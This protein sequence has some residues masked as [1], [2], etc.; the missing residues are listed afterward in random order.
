MDALFIKWAGPDTGWAT[1]WWACMSTDSYPITVDGVTPYK[2][3][4]SWYS[5][6]NNGTYYPRVDIH[7]TGH[8]LGLPDYYDYDAGTGPKGGVGGWDMMDA[9]WGDHNAFSKY[10]LGWIDPIVISSG[11]REINL[12]P[13]STTST[14]NAVLIMPRAAPDSFG[15][16]FLV[17]YREPGS[18]NDPLKAGLGKAVWI[19]HVDSTLS[20]SGW[21]YLYDNS[22]TTHKLL[23]LM[24]AD[25]LEEIESGTGNWDGDDFYRSRSGTGTSD[26]AEYQYVYRCENECCH[27][28]PGDKATLPCM[29]ISEYS[30]MARLQI[31]SQ[32]LLQVPHRSLCSSR[33]LQRG[34]ESQPGSGIL[35]TT[36]LLTVRPGTRPTLT[37]LR[38]PILSTS[39]SP[40]QAG[41]TA[42]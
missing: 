35:T 38:E 29:W 20:G 19:W 18:G 1:F 41:A 37:P 36:R 2:Y 33:I 4:W 8:L 3:V 15:E 27:Q 14:E 34:Q 26:P 21:G 22:Y 12:P 39:R 13:T 16:F 5:R 40:G 9:N 28:Y 6:P 24:E 7:E 17:Q 10:L 42:K 32:M 25:G 30:R 31:L 23:R 11:T